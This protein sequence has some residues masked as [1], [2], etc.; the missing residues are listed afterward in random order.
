MVVEGEEDKVMESV[1]VM[2]MVLKMGELKSM[3]R[4]FLVAV[5][6]VVTVVVIVIVVLMDV[7]VVTL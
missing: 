7:L 2:A 5:V 4:Y 6:V 3:R 1:L